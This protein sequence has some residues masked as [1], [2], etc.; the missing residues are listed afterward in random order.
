M[1]KIQKVKWTTFRHR[2]KTRMFV[3]DSK[4][5]VVSFSPMNFHISLD[6]YFFQLAPL[7]KTRIG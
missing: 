1:Q 2:S 3:A 7:S 5:A 4:T 6:L